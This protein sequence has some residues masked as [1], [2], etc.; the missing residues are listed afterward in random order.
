MR[1]EGEVRET[2]AITGDRLPVIFQSGI[3][4]IGQRRNL[5]KKTAF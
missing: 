2:R 3:G 1:G 4:Q 5:V